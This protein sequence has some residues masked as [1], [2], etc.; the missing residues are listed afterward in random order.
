MV[1]DQVFGQLACLNMEPDLADDAKEMLN[2][3]SMDLDDFKFDFDCLSD[4]LGPWIQPETGD[5]GENEADSG[6]NGPWIQSNPLELNML[7]EA[8]DDLDIKS[9][10]TEFEDLN[11]TEAVRYDCMW[12]SN[13]T[14]LS[15]PPKKAPVPLCENT[16]F[17][18]FL[19]II[20]IPNQ[21]DL[22]AAES[23]H[24][25]PHSHKDP[26]KLDKTEPLLTDGDSD[27][28]KSLSEQESK[29]RM[30]TWL[31]HCYISTTGLPNRTSNRQCNFSS[32]GFPATPPESSED[33]EWQQSSPFPHV[34]NTET[35]T[36]TLLTTNTKNITNPTANACN[37]SHSLLKKSRATPSKSPA[38]SG[39]EAKFCFR[40]K[41]KPEKSRS[42]L[43]N[44]LRLTNCSSSRMNNTCSSNITSSS[45]N[46]SSHISSSHSYINSGQLK[47]SVCSLTSSSF[48]TDNQHPLITTTP[49][50][51]TGKQLVQARQAS[52]RRRKEESLKLKH[53]EAREIH[54]HMERQRRNEL[55]V[56]FDELK[57][58]I[59]EIAT[60][61]KVSKQMI[62]DTAL[63]N[64]KFIKSKQIGLKLRKE[65]LRKCNAELR[66]KLKCLQAGSTVDG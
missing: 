9:D 50:T 39:G 15:A 1:M 43:K 53:R 14:S 66:E 21:F 35:T 5:G 44:K 11:I 31:D 32:S 48:L 56:A 60:S 17:E 7:D 37:R 59:P 6:L 49:A 38:G 46:S 45:R 23:K 34:I 40:C 33:E 3:I 63:Q 58:C 19:K 8:D 26:L 2:E 55:K 36:T 54:N 12:S 27:C 16:L 13:A 20:D 47:T 29:V 57:G 62:L 52:I 65:K 10:I 22:D 28:D 25:H 64:C 42:L 61:D 24:H 51:L 30:N 18:E 41:F 4:S